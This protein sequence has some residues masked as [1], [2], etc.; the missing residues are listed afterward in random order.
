MEIAAVAGTFAST[1][2]ASLS[3]RTLLALMTSR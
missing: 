1:D 3:V 2:T